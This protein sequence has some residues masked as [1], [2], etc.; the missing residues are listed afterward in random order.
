MN[1]II[2]FQKHI[3]LSFA[4][5]FFASC[6]TKKD[7]IY[8]QDLKD[9]TKSSVNY[10]PSFIQV[11]DILF[12]KVSTLVAEASEPFN[13]QTTG[14][15]NFN[16]QTFKIQSYLVDKNGEIS[17]PILGS[18][19]VSGKTTIQVQDEIIKLLKDDGYLKDPTV[20]C[21]IINSKVTVLGEVKNPG[22]FSFEEQ[23]ITLNQALG[24][25]G[26]LTIYGNRKD[27]LVIRDINGQRTYVHLDLTKSD[28][29]ESDYYFVKQND[30][31]IVSPNGPKV[32]SSGYLN[33]LGTTLGLASLALT[34]Y[35][36]L[37]NL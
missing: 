3:V 27:V 23:N 28:W 10:L 15:S 24:F 25:A 35:L 18:L 6:A 9:N 19:K 33:S 12:I 4:L 5:L 13:I 17:F 14:S 36:V 20:N 34:I 29:F 37:K 22:T 16:I 30:V 32:M 31:I 21:R 11:N 2:P 8:Y 26:D 1:Q 7:L